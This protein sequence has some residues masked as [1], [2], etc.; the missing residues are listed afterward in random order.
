MWARF[1]EWMRE[2]FVELITSLM[3]LSKDFFFWVVE[4]VLDALLWII[5]QVPVPEW[6]STGL[7]ALFD[8]L[9]QGTLYIL[10]A[11]GIGP[12]LAMIGAGYLFR[13]TRKVV[14]LFQW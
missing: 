6:M 2:L 1:T 5:E 3:E 8:P 12:G 13:L 11:V 9:P 7:Q 4:N 10:G 14:T